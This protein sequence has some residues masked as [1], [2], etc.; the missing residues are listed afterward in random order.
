MAGTRAVL[1]GM[2]AIALAAAGAIAGGTEAD[3]LRHSAVVDAVERDGPA[4]VN[5]STEQVVER[6]GSPF[7]F[8]EDPFFDQFFR[9]FFDA[10]PRRFT[11]TSLGS[12]SIVA[13]DGTVLTN[14]HVVLRAS[15]IHVTLADGRELPGKLVGADV[16]SDI[17]VVKIQADGLPALTMGTS[18][19]LMIGETVIAIGN[20]F[21]LSNTVTTGVV[22][23]L[24]RSL[25]SDDHTYTD[26]IQTDAAINPG[27][28]GGPLLNIHG[29]LIG[30]NTA[31]YSRSGGN[32]G[33]GFAIPI[34]RA[35]RVMHDLVAF[36]EVR[37]GWIGLVVQDLTPQ[38]AQHFGAKKG[39]VVTAVEPDSPAAAAGFARGDVV[40][41]IDG[42]DVRS[43]EEFEER[44][45]AHGAGEPLAVTRRRDGRDE[46]VRLAAAGFPES[47]ADALAWRALGLDVRQ[48]DD[49]LAVARVR[50]GSPVARIGVQR[51]DRLLGLGGTPLRSVAEFRRRMIE[52]RAKRSV[53]VS[54]GRGPFEYNVNV[55]LAR[56]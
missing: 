33:I 48:S 54:I 8:P 38:L 21:G 23:A 9:D 27:N 52:L 51:G 3:P 4:V 34:D 24:G 43:S 7:R 55:P 36:G 47:A 11:Y 26:L 40:T 37:R 18:A 6:P 45:A 44:V 46:D 39:V 25:R 22:S 41:R 13:S 35:R 42:H 16:D 50:P 14:E 56:G 20:P 49:G 30:I 10:R 12:G 1:S 17:A 31:I 19:D 53:L 28:S 29:A 32:I 5:I 15:K 2:L